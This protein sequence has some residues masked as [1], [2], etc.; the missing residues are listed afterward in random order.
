MP[1]KWRH[2]YVAALA[3]GNL[4]G[5]TLAK[6]APPL[7]THVHDPWP[8][9][10]DRG[11]AILSG[12]F[13][14][15]GE[16]HII[17]DVVSGVDQKAS[18][19]WLGAWHGFE[20]LRDVMVADADG[21]RHRNHIRHRIREWIAKGHPRKTIA[22]RSDV[23][24]ARIQAWCRV[25]SYLEEDEALT[26]AM[27]KSLT[28]QI[29]H[30]MRVRDVQTPREEAFGVFAGMVCAA[31]A[32]PAL[33]AHAIPPALDHCHRALK[34]Q[35]RPD[36][37]HYERSPRVHLQVMRHLIDLREHL[38]L[39]RHE[40]PDFLDR[41]ITIMGQTLAHLCHPDGRLP[42]FN[43]SDEGSKRII[44]RALKLSGSLPMRVIPPRTHG[45]HRIHAGSI[46]LIADAGYNARYPSPQ[47]PSPR[48]RHAG[49]GSVEVSIGQERIIV[50][51]GA[52]LGNQS[53]WRH[54]M[55]SS[56]VHSTLTVNDTNSD[57]TILGEND[58]ADR[59]R[60]RTRALS[61]WQCHEEHD[62]TWLDIIHQGYQ[63][64][65]RLTHR[66]KLYLARDD[67]RGEDMV[68]S[69][70]QRRGEYKI[71]IRFHL[72]P[73]I[74]VHMISERNT[75][76][77][78]T[79]HHGQWLLRTRGAPLRLERSVYIGNGCRRRAS[80]QLVARKQT[81]NGQCTVKWALQ[82][83]SYSGSGD[84]GGYTIR[85]SGGHA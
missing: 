62:K 77:L 58:R 2:I 66:R 80:L 67:L 70:H 12:R 41:A 28:R 72:H 25:L 82:P 76:V 60:H 31:L 30:L 16:T 37:F 54:C 85:P 1:F 81:E 84:I 17:R 57:W 32:M 26:K 6:K 53:E 22:W 43:D 56:S 10:P 20:W 79:A 45:F 19:P 27:G 63:R 51:G 15:Q 48:H 64:P 39:A 14:H 35:L 46:G 38:R 52:F 24:G 49:T 8:G 36:G 9:D 75:A 44:R 5:W 34:R 40:S 55:R 61:Q 4:Y 11:R 3:T 59:K 50:N 71:D 18:R 78:R 73:H 65:Y 47:A 69:A 74:R 23:I 68:K 29:R 33:F 42:L 7:I 21:P 13:I 83:L